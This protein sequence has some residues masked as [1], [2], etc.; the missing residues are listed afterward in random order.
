M[1]LHI[2]GEDKAEVERP[3]L[4]AV[5][6]CSELDGHGGIRAVSHLGGK[7]DKPI[8]IGGSL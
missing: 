3:V 8:G 5:E 6:V 1:G 7:T 2:S 4:V